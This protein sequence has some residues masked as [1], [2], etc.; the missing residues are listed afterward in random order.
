MKRKQLLKNL[1][2]TFD[3]CYKIADKKNKDYAGEK[4]A[5]QNFNASEIVGVSPERAI[6]V[7]LTD[8]ITRISNL[9]D[10][11]ADVD[12]SFEDTIKDAINYLAL[13]NELHKKK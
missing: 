3:D 10:K 4:N 1:K 7:R 5:F 2:Q 12:E 11:E 13:L 9:L 6:L 8:K